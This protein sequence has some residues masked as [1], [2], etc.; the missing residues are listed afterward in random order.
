ML[1]TWALFGHFS[2]IKTKNKKNCPQDFFLSPQIFSDPEKKN[3][4]FPFRTPER[5]MSLFYSF[6]QDTHTDI[7]LYIYLDSCTDIMY[8]CTQLVQMK[9]TSANKTHINGTHTHTFHCI[10]I[11]S[12]TDL[13]LGLHEVLHVFICFPLGLA[14]LPK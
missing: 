9:C 13:L 4:K 6:K 7:A 1:G 10:Y 8:H 12:F 5:P 3:P 11:Y 2:F 14:F